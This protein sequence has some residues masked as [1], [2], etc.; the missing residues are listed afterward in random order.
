MT[1]KRT[2]SARLEMKGG[3]AVKAVLTDVARVGDK[4]FKSLGDGAKSAADKIGS[5]KSVKSILKSAS[6]GFAYLTAGVGAVAGAFTFITKKAFDYAGEIKDMSAQANLSVESM[7]SLKYVA[8]QLGIEIDTLRSGFNNFT[9]SADEFATS[10]GG[11][12][13]SAFERLGFTQK[14]VNEGLSDT[15]KLFGEVIQRLR[16]TKDGAAQVNLSR[17]FFGK[18]GGKNFVLF[19]KESADNIAKLRDEANKL[20]LVLSAEMIDKADEASDKIASMAYVLQTRAKVAIIENADA[21]YE[22]IEKVSENLPSAIQKV[23]GFANAIGLIDGRS[24]AEKLSDLNREIEELDKRI[25]DPS[26]FQKIGN[27]KDS[28]F[29]DDGMKASYMPWAKRPDPNQKKL[30]GLLQQRRAL[31]QKTAREQGSLYG[32]FESDKYTAVTPSSG[33]G[34]RDYVSPTGGGRKSGTSDADSIRQKLAEM[35]KEIALSKESAREQA[36]LRGERSLGATATDAQRLKAREFALALYDQNEAIDAARDATNKYDSA[37]QSVANTLDNTLDNVLSGNIRSFSDWGDAVLDI[38]GSVAKEFTLMQTG[39]ESISSIIAGSL[40][41]ALDFS[42]PAATATPAGRAAG[43]PVSAGSIYQWQER[44]KEYFI[45][46][47]NGM[48]VPSSKMGGSGGNVN[49][50][51]INNSNAQVSTQTKTAGGDREIMLMID[52]AVANNL[53]SPS[54]RSRGALNSIMNPDIFRR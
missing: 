31:E 4:S 34:G 28:L 1:E 51:V 37:V 54:S 25:S 17:D 6:E 30:D 10:G 26:F 33:S 50:T 32:P 16:E 12:A 29:N 13:A 14:Q 20:G 24:A 23:E 48:V 39:G 49:V 41:D 11:A 45:P 40:F 19:V 5:L 43:G 44:E 15:D 52:Q 3:E 46:S 22:L 27:L 2:Y 35:E 36:A 42:A 47:S 18:E 9:A 38:I 53:S 7:Q 21:I 8:V